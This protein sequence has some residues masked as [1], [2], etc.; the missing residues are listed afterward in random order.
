MQEPAQS[1]LTFAQAKEFLTGNDPRAAETLRQVDLFFRLR[2]KEAGADDEKKLESLT[3]LVIAKLR[4]HS[5]ETPEVKKYFEEFRAGL[6]SVLR[7]RL[8]G[9]A[10]GRAGVF[11]RLLR[12]VD[13]RLGILYD[14]TRRTQVRYFLATAEN[15]VHALSRAYQAVGMSD[16]AADL[17]V[18]RMDLKRYA[19]LTSG[20]WTAAA[21]LQF[22]KAIS[23]YGTSL[24]R[25]VVTCSL[26]LVFF[27]WVYW[28]ADWAAAPDQRMITDLGD[29]SKYLFNSLVTI[30]GLG[31][32][33]SPVT[34]PQ[35]LAMGINAVYGMVIVG[36]LMNVVSTKLSINN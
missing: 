4:Q 18:L 34:W 7:R 3:F 35:R 13:G 16:R 24:G 29:V 17:Y 8:Y 26:S 36:L 33:A 19:A 23:G 2:A 10:D 9:A 12:T 22:F 5:L 25:L 28:L 11:A 15:Y 30:T 31:I 6:R 1:T 20:R 27:A 14:R 21:G 32:D